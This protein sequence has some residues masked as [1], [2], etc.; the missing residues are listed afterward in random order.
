MNFHTLRMRLLGSV[1]ASLLVAGLP[2]WS[3]EQEKAGASADELVKRAIETQLKDPG[4]NV[5]FMYRI[6]RQT[7]ERDE[8]REV[9]ET[10]DGTLTRLIM[11]NGKA[12]SDD[13]QRAEQDRLNRYINEPSQ[14]QQ[15][16]KRQKEDEDRSNKMLEAMPKAF[17]YTYEG[18]ESGPNGEQLTRLNFKPNPIYQAPNRELRVFEGMEGKMW[19]NA[20]A[21]RLVRMQAKLIRDVDFG[22]GILGRLYRG[23]SFEIEQRDIGDGRWDVVKTILNFDGKELML[24]GLHI[25]DTESLSDFHRVPEKI[26]LAQGIKMLNEYKPGQDAVAQQVS[27]PAM[28]GGTPPK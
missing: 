26:T 25:K 6:H 15:R 24:K 5:H 9:L 23:G 28:G 22:W 18:T 7:P 17:L 14:W 21:N 27:R 11:S 2:L 16:R 8:V 10:S 13:Q 3:Q 12:L 19:V 1:L 4:G 20:G